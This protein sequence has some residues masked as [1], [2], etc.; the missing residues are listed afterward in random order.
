MI[1]HQKQHLFW[2]KNCSL[3]S[4][5]QMHAEVQDLCPVT[6]FF[7]LGNTNVKSRVH[8][9]TLKLV[10]TRNQILIRYWG[11]HSSGWICIHQNYQGNVW[12]KEGSHYSLQS[13]N[14]SYGDTRI[15]SIALQNWTLGTQYQKN[16]FLF[17]CG[18]LRS[19]IFFQRW[20]KS[21]PK[22]PENHYAISTDWDGRNY[23]GLT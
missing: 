14:F 13:A 1:H 15:L 6:W 10:P 22:L 8:E 4:Q 19:K 5:F 18:W 3:I 21:P 23:L 16:N 2:S 11:T 17:M 20:C 9:D 7:F 12:T